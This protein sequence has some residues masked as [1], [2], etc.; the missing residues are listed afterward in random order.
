M[1]LFPIRTGFAVEEQV[2]DS[3]ICNRW[4]WVGVSLCYVHSRDYSKVTLLFAGS[5]LR[6]F[7]FL[8]AN[9]QEYLLLCDLWRLFSCCMH[10][11]TFCIVNIYYLFLI[12][13]CFIA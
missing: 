4:R 9:M 3:D 13:G 10:M 12:Q 1:L 6:K 2:A 5:I 8:D 11:P 7:V